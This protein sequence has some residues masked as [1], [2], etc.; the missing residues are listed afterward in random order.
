M[1]SGNK[2]LVSAVA[3]K[4]QFTDFE[5]IKAFLHHRKKI[6]WLQGVQQEDLLLMKNADF[7]HSKTKICYFFVRCLIK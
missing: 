3:D 4:L 1:L 6:N 7:M 2:I 5:C